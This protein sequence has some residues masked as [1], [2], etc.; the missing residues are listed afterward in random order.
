MRFISNSFNFNI[1]GEARTAVS[2]FRSVDLDI[3][4]FAFARTLAV[5]SV[6]VR[7]HSSGYTAHV[8]AKLNQPRNNQ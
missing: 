6:A 4:G 8:Q 3:N 2:S 7:S 5:A 1:A